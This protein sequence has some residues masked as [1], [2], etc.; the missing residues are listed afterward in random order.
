MLMVF[1]YRDLLIAEYLRSRLFG[2][3]TI[4]P[5]FQT[6]FRRQRERPERSIFTAFWTVWFVIKTKDGAGDG[7]EN[8]H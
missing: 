7:I 3:I 2:G 4:C 6:V 5:R 1:W 8:M